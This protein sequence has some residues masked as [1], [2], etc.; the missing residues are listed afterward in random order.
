MLLLKHHG[1]SPESRPR[2]KGLYSG[3]PR[4]PSGGLCL[5]GVQLCPP[6]PAGLL[7]QPNL[8]RPCQCLLC[9]RRPLLWRL[10]LLLA[11][12][13]WRRRGA[14]RSLLRRLRLR[15]PLGLLAGR[16]R[17]ADRSLLGRLRLLLGLLAGGR[18]GADRSLLRR[19]RLRL[20]LLIGL[21]AGRRRRAD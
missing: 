18:R 6:S 17:G 13:A 15:L 8:K 4:T 14:D 5:A 11:L 20:R 7:S 21:L 10:G 1:W 12:L 3:P 9:D 19:L 16:R 2:L